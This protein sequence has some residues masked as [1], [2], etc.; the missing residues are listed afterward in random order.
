LPR[1]AGAVNR[2][3]EIG[4]EPENGNRKPIAGAL[5]PLA[6]ANGPEIL[7]KAHNLPPPGNQT[8]P[9]DRSRPIA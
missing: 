5:G 7:A 4:C 6:E 3:P 2:S 1:K 9:P 8:G